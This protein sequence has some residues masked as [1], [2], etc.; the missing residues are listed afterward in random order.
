MSV[1]DIAARSTTRVHWDVA[2]N[3]VKYGAQRGGDRDPAGR[4]VGGSVAIAWHLMNL[5]DAVD[6]T[7]HLGVTTIDQMKFEP[8]VSSVGGVVETITATPA[9]CRFLV[10][11]ELDA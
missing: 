8:R 5:Q 2:G 9:G 10:R 4:L 6:M 7:R 1:L 3:T 11:K